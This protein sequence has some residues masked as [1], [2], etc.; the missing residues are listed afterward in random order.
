MASTPQL[1]A[2]LR[3]VQALP[4][5]R[6]C[7]D[8]GCK[9]PQWASVTYGVF[10]CLECSGMHR[11]L[12]VH[13][14]FVRS[15]GMDSWTEDQVRRMELGGNAAVNSFMDRY[16][17]ESFSGTAD[18]TK[19]YRSQA[20]MAFRQK[21]DAE[22]CGLAYKC[23]L[24]PVMKQKSSSSS[25]TSSVR[26]DSRS[27]SGCSASTARVSDSWDDWGEGWGSAVS[28]RS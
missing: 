11:S 16:S 26:K 8:C 22:A 23:E 24:Q 7:V 6:Q 17:A 20:A 9:N 4:C 14:S 18:V 10:M 5:N 2:R 27:R 3:R 1:Q 25:A 13:L 15:V 28:A 12:G 19:K 21:L